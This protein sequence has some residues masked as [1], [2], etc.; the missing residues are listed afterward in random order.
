MEILSLENLSLYAWY[1][2]Y[3][4]KFVIVDV[5]DHLLSS[6]PFATL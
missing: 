5:V 2:V 3:P 6:F 4:I 1:P